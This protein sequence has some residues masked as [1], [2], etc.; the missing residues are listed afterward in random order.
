MLCWPAE[1]PG[2]A[3][4]QGGGKYPGHSLQVQPFQVSGADQF[5]KSGIK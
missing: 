4:Q 5:C 2:E 3:D 1:L